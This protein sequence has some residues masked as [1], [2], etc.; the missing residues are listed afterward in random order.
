M[1]LI[2]GFLCA[3]LAHNQSTRLSP[4]Q[5][6]PPGRF[7]NVKTESNDAPHKHSQIVI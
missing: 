4:C 1:D 5:F 3:P 2:R 7:T 6:W